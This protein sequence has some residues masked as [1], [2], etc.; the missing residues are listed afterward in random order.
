MSN[1]IQNVKQIEKKPDGSSV[2]FGHG[3]DHRMAGRRGQPESTHSFSRFSDPAES[4]CYSEMGR[5]APSLS[6]F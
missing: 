2:R 3:V 1:S 6:Q 5:S 4:A